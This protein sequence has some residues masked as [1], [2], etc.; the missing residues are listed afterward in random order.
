M[1]FT[2]IS[3]E[4]KIQFLKRIGNVLITFQSNSCTSLWIE[5]SKA[6]QTKIPTA[7]HDLITYNNNKHK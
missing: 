4:I 1:F 2:V 6:A 3:S 7:Y 5:S